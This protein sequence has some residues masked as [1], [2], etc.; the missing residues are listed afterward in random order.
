MKSVDAS[1]SGKLIVS[2][3]VKKANAVRGRT[4]IAAAHRFGAV[5]RWYYTPN[6][7]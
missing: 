7:G 2:R 4:P 6:S 1:N 3:I 5:R